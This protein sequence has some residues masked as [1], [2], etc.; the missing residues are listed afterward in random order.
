MMIGIVRNV[1]TAHAAPSSPAM[2]W[3]TKPARSSIAGDHDRDGRLHER[4]RQDAVELGV[5]R[6]DRA[7]RR[8]VS[9]PSSRSFA[10]ATS[11]AGKYVFTKASAM[12]ATTRKT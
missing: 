4:P 10:P 6:A 8:V 12:Y 3:P 1:T 7:R 11:A 9:R 2:I 5:R